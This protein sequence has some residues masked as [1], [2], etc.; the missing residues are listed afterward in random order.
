[1]ARPNRFTIPTSCDIVM[2]L[3]AGAPKCEG[4]KGYYRVSATSLARRGKV[5]QRSQ[6][7]TRSGTLLRRARLRME[8]R[9]TAEGSLCKPPPASILPP[10]TTGTEDM[11]RLEWF[12]YGFTFALIVNAFLTTTPAEAVANLAAWFS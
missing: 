6:T 3:A 10:W 1:M 11:N 8:L 7:T 4:R 2:R 12:L 9:F 5:D